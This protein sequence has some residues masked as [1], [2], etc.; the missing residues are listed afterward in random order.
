MKKREGG[1]KLLL[2]SCSGFMMV[3]R[4]ILDVKAVD[5]QVTY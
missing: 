5:L 4:K 3:S 2:K 1:E